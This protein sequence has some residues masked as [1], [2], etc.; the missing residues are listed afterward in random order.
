MTIDTEAISGYLNS[1][2]VFTTGGYHPLM[3]IFATMQII[4]ILIGLSKGF[5]LRELS[6]RVMKQGI[7]QKSTQ[8][9]IVVVAHFIDMILFEGTNSMVFI[10]LIAY[11][12]NEGLSIV[13]SAAEMDVLVPDS[14]KKH[15]KQVQERSES[16]EVKTERDGDGHFSTIVKVKDS[17]CSNSEDQKKDK[18]KTDISPQ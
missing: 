18:D 17:N 7:S 14:L 15:L 3:G 10:V 5:Y 4:D 2:L 11:I 1:F 12:A 6:S 13:E 9:L 16:V 8:W